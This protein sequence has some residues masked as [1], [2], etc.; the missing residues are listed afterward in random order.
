[1]LLEQSQHASVHAAICR[2]CLLL[3]DERFDEWLAMC[4]PE[5][6]Y[7]IQTYSPEIRRQMTWLKHDRARLEQ[8]LSTLHLH[9]RDSGNLLR[10]PSIL[11]VERGK[12]GTLDT[13][14]SVLIF[15]TAQDGI[16]GLFAAARYFDT[17][18]AATDQLLLKERRV[19]LATRVLMSDAGG[20]HVP[21]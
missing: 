21:L 4:A 15:R 3:D 10:H 5:V 7:S 17:W 8:M 13:M 12:D 1:M 16:T 9:Q 14:S 18:N 6:S 19:Q 11:Q 20:S 2:T